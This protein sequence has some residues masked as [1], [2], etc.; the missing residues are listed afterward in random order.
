[1]TTFR[2]HKPSSGVLYSS[3]KNCSQHWGTT[4][5]LPCRGKRFGGNLPA[6]HPLQPSVRCGLEA[7]LATGQAQERNREGRGMDLSSLWCLHQAL[8]LA[9]FHTQ[10]Q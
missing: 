7:E 1:M 10:F 6:Q 2:K 4:N 8:S 5:N 3:T 9:L